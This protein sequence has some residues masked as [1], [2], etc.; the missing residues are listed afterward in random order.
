[1]KGDDYGQNPKK[2]VKLGS[3]ISRYEDSS[4]DIANNLSNSA[5]KEGVVNANAL[6]QLQG[7]LFNSESLEQSSNSYAI[8]GGNLLHINNTSKFVLKNDQIKL[9][10]KG[11]VASVSDRFFD[12]ICNAKLIIDIEKKAYPIEIIAE[13][14]S[15]LRIGEKESG[16][17]R[18]IKIIVDKEMKISYDVLDGSS[19]TDKNQST[20][21]FYENLDTVFDNVKGCI[22]SLKQDISQEPDEREIFTKISNTAYDKIPSEIEMS[23]TKRAANYFSNLPKCELEN[24]KRVFLNLDNKGLY[25]SQN[26]CRAASY[27]FFHQYVSSAIKGEDIKYEKNTENELGFQNRMVKVNGVAALIHYAGHNKET[28]SEKKLVDPKVHEEY[29]NST[30]GKPKS[31]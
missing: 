9:I 3:Y 31:I 22:N 24:T 27:G 11:N 14:Q 28:Q 1:M 30:P 18:L 12:A 10:D 4:Y 26:A 29:I 8:S 19:L 20:K 15:K 21:E 23:K 5:S 7:N 17:A 6:T 2:K 16:H 25:S 13:I